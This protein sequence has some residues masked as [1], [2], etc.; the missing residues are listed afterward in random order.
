MGFIPLTHM[1][2]ITLV[3]F[4]SRDL[5][6]CY[7]MVNLCNKPRAERPTPLEEPATLATG[8]NRPDKAEAVKAGAS[9]F[10]AK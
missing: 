2:E 5:L 10:K 4:V 7:T 9:R 6:F 1:Q 8:M 3:M